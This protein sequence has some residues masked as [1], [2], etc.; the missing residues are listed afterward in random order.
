MPLNDMEC[1][2]NGAKCVITGRGFVFSEI[3][4]MR[5]GRGVG[6]VVG[7]GMTM[8]VGALEVSAAG[9]FGSKAVLV[10]EGGVPRTLAV[11][12]RTVDGVR[13]VS[14]DGDRVVVEFNGRRHALKVGESVVHRPA[15]EQEELLLEADSQ[16]HFF[17][18]GQINGGAIRLIVDTGASV[19]SLGRSDAVRLGIDLTRGVP[20]R[21]QTAG[22]V[23]PIRLVRLD[24]LRIGPFVLNDVE[25]AVHEIDLPIALLGMSVLNRMEMVRDGSRMVLRKRY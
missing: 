5:F 2:T 16:G 6:L 21:S 15:S 19:V 14:V 12:E 20:A 22:G 24:S 18:N 4:L 23:R 11:G 3:G 25:A 13:L 1:S 9:V 10:V 8:P 17:V 7:M